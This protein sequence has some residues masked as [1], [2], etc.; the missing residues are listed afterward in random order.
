MRDDR[1]LRSLAIITRLI[2]RGDVTN[3]AS[4]GCRGFG[5]EFLFGV[6]C[7]SETLLMRFLRRFRERGH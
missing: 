4:R 5:R 7:C 2:D 1:E 3:R 6:V